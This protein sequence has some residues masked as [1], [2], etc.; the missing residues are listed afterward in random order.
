MNYLSVETLSK[1]FGDKVLFQNISFGIDQGQKIALVGIN[2]SGKSTLMKIIMGLEETD[3]GSVTFRNDIKVTFVHQNP[4]FAD[5]QSVAE[6]VFYNSD[7]PVLQT[8]REYQLTLIKSETDLDAQDQLTGLFEKMDTY[9]AWDYESQVKQIL[10]RLGIHNL[11]QPISQLSG[12]QRKRVALA[13]ALV[14]KPDLIDHG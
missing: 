5:N 11:E 2:G 14:E 9:N 13:K 12:G 4:T 3:A 7:D 8:I 10:G 6:A 1:A